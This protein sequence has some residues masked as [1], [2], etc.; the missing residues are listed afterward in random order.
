MK[1]RTNSVLLTALAVAIGLAPGTGL[2]FSP[3][4]QF[5]ETSD[6]VYVFVDQLSS[7]T[8]AQRQFA[9]SHYVGTQKQLSY[10]ID[11]IRVYNPDFIHLQYRLGVRESGHAVNY[12]H[13]N[14]WS[15][16]WAWIN[17][18]EDWFVHHWDTNPDPRLYQWYAPA[19]HEEYV[20][21]CSGLI[22]GNTTYG[23]KEYWSDCV[24]NDCDDSHAD[25][26]FADSTHLP[27]SI[28]ADQYASPLGSP[29]HTAYI[30]DLEVFYDYTYQRFNEANKYFIP[31]VGGLMTTVDTTSG[32]YEDVHGVM[33]EGYG[34]KWSEFDWR[35]Q[36]NR[37]LRLLRN[38]KIYIAQN[39]VDGP[40]DI[41]GRK[42]LFS[43]FMLLKHDKSFINMFPGG[44]QLYWWPEYDLDLGLQ[45]DPTVPG[46]VAG[47]LDSGGI[48]ARQYEGGLVL[49][50][51]TGST[52]SYA[53]TG[54]GTYNLIEPWGGGVVDSAGNPPAGG[55]TLTEVEGS[56]QL[57]SW[58]GA[59][60]TFEPQPPPSVEYTFKYL[61][62]GKYGLTFSVHGNDEELAS[63]FADMSFEGSGGGQIQ[64]QKAI[65]IPGVLEY[66]V[67][68][69]AD[70][71]LYD[72]QGTPPYE[73]DRDSYFLE[74]FSS[75]DVMLLEK[76]ENYYHMEAGTGAASKYEVAPLAYIVC[77]GDVAFYGA[78]SRLAENYDVSEIA[79][80]PPPGDAN[81][82]GLVDGGDYTIWCDNYS[83][84]DLGWAGADFNGDGVVDGGDY[85]IWADFYGTGSAAVPEPATAALLALSAL[86]LLLKRRG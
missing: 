45:T 76:A 30:P 51:P 77:D 31:N 60:L 6:G 57:G 44:S 62:D 8:V 70:A 22:E 26:V 68:A 86:G 78:I 48:Y 65:I 9:A 75:G 41:S 14:S 67:D 11:A 69:E 2:A 20:M 33:V 74:P 42:W 81:R 58:S 82:D 1:V 53:L 4:R 34:T 59:V 79:V 15:N 18:H 24:I 71:D 55:L 63:F 72:G 85:T 36:Q 54:N 35:L 23:W 38:G 64:Q 27:Y 73:K 10:Q 16:D 80:L 12:I 40:S 66:E 50:N 7:M 56:V 84:T 37:V 47:L 61:G 19:G 28:P 46:D 43:N 29:P 49:V 21:D 52:H 83:A 25:G 13:N 5:P 39:G 3:A 32:Y 17:L